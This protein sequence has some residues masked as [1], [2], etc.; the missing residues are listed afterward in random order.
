ML[1]DR[2]EIM[3]QL[4]YEIHKMLNRFQNLN[5]CEWRRLEEW[6]NLSQDC[7]VER[8]RY[9]YSMLSEEDVHIIMLIRVGL[10]H[11]EIA[12]I[13][14]VTLKSFKMRRYRMKKKMKIECSSFTEFI[15]GLY[16][17]SVYK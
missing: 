15:L 12:H 16:R 11:K 2:I 14:N 10:T 7:F 8:V 5:R 17:E 1:I 4:P 13:G 3:N 6:I 9:D